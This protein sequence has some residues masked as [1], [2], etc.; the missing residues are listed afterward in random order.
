[1]IRFRVRSEEFQR[2]STA[3]ISINDRIP[4]SRK[5]L[6]FLCVLK[7]QHPPKTF[8]QVPY[9]YPQHFL[10]INLLFRLLSFLFH[11]KN[12]INMQTIYFSW[13]PFYPL[14][15]QK[16]FKRLYL[17]RSVEILSLFTFHLFLIYST[18]LSAQA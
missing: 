14:R 13:I 8:T 18:F 10:P 7:F 4:N 12:S 17:L 9:S 2:I 5:Q 15:K 16:E 1:M 3:R 11:F 6:T